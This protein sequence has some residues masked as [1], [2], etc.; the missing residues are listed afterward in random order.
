VKITNDLL[1]EV[2]GIYRAY[3]TD[4]PTQA[5]ADHYDKSHRTAGGYVKAARERIDPDTGKPFLGPALRGRA[6]EKS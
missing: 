3:V 5:I 1:R 6:G 4:N 2:A